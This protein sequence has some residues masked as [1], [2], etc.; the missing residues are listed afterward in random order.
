MI[1]N[2]LS[3]NRR[4]PHDRHALATLRVD[5]IADLAC[6]WCY[7]G[8]RRLDAALDAVQGPT[9]LTWLP[10]QLNPDMPPEGQLFEEYLRARFGDPARVQPGLDE[11]TRTGAGEGIRF[12]FDLIRRVPN[13]LDAHRLLKYAEDEG[14]SSAALGEGLLSGFFEEGLDITD[15][16]ALIAIGGNHG[17]TRSGI[18]RALDDEAGREAVLAKEAQ[19]RGGGITGVP[20]FLVNNRLIVLGAQPTTVLVDAFDRAMFGDESDQPV[21]DSVH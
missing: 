10:F 15:R 1:E 19:V 11:L 4:T 8:K 6:P 12:R 18:N 9:E 7:L 16:E 13:T 21:S 5:L 17:L 14:L 2:S 20:D 3:H